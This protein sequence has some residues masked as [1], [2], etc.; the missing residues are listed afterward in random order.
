MDGGQFR[1]YGGRVE[2][3]GE[4]SPL[5][6]YENRVGMCPP[7]ILEK[8]FMTKRAYVTGNPEFADLGKR[9]SGWVLAHNNVARAVNT[10][11]GQR[12]F[13]CFWIDPNWTKW[14]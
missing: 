7:F 3:G 5:I 13:R 12:G 9:P 4:Y 1:V 8:G 10:Q 6:F 11:H 2:R 14:R